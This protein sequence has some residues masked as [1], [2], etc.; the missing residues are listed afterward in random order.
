MTTPPP[1]HGILGDFVLASG[2]ETEA[3]L[4]SVPGFTVVSAPGGAG[5]AAIRGAARHG[6][7]PDGTHWVG[8][9]DLVAGDLATGGA[10]L[11]A[12]APPQA[13]WRGRFAQ[14][15]WSPAARRAVAL[16][17]HIS[18]LAIYTLVRG[19]V[20]VVG[21]DF[22]L[23]ASSPWCRRTIDLESVYHYLNFAQIPAPGTIFREIRRLE[24]ATKMA[25]ATSGGAP[26]PTFAQYFTPEYPG[27]LR[28]SDEELARELRERMIANVE[29]YRP[30]GDAPDW[31][32]FLSG[33]TDSSSIVSIL[34]GRG[35]AAGGAARPR[36]RSFSIGFAE[37]GYD[38]LDFARTAAEACGAD[39][40]FAK[41]SREQ[42][43]G[44]VTRVVEAYD[45][46]FGNAS[47]I[48]TLACADLAHERG[49]TTLLA[50]DGGDE[51]FGG[52][53]RYAKDRIMETWYGLPAP[54]KELGNAI[55]RAAG[56]SNVHILNRV[57]NFFARSSIPNPDRF[58]TDDSF[59]SD[60][61]HELLSP[62]FRAAV[63]RDASLDF[64][65]GV[66]RQGGD[67]SPLHR[68]MR[69]DLNMAIARNDIPKVHWATRSA[70]VSVRFPYLDP[71]LI[72]YTGRLAERYKVRGIEKRYLFKRAM[73]GI[74]PEAIL[75]KKKQ[76]FGLPIAVWLRSDDAFKGLVRGTLFDERTRA[77]GWWEPT[78]IDKLLVEHEKGAWDHADSIWRLFI[79]ERWLRRFVDG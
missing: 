53:Q 3:W 17:D 46:P 1:P 69:L 68:I 51:I 73:E 14:A 43:Q 76:G 10:A 37:A 39:P 27:D 54:I 35:N 20:I 24:P 64:M 57:E 33:G 8:L 9:A 66:F 50:G 11:A 70:G 22:R 30:A 63:P 4:R 31:G 7:T 78:F 16:T 59:A 12:G 71:T 61:Y 67:A 26:A 28:G 77:R 75:R 52:N 40:T 19:D 79:L 49:M 58:Y 72:A 56:R 13:A 25:W 62:A 18:T 21:T 42:A 74:L 32:C 29:A 48:P 55:G 45:Q 44:L 65:R 60:H 2:P 6:V 41:V 34:S 5:Q 15:T 38:E 23:L 47:A 36:V